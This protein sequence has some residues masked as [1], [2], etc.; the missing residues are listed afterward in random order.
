MNFTSRRDAGLQHMTATLRPAVATD[1]P[2]L[3]RLNEESVNFLSPLEAPALTRLLAMAA[4]CTVSQEGEAGPV[5]GFLLALRE[6]AAYDSPNYAWFGAR[7]D[8]FLYVDRVVIAGSA[9]GKGRGRALYQSLFERARASGVAL[10]TAEF[11]VDPPNEPS[12]RLHE[13]FGFREVGRQRLAAGK[14]VSLQAARP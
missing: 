12:R 3:L 14:V 10:I 13:S 4:F 11:D 6:G 1:A 2:A 5:D 7:Y 9:Q 8:T